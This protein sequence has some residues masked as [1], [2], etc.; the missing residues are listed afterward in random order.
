MGNEASRDH[1]PHH[2]TFVDHEGHTYEIAA[3]QTPHQTTT[4]SKIEDVATTDTPESPT[5]IP[6]HHIPPPENNYDDVVDPILAAAAAGA[7]TKQTS[8]ER[9]RHQIA[10]S[11]RAPF[12]IQIDSDWQTSLQRLAK[13][14]KST[15]QTIA[16][17]AAPIMQEAAIVMKE[18]TA[19][20]NKSNREQS[21]C[22][23][24]INQGYQSTL[25]RQ[26]DL[27]ASRE[28]QVTE[29]NPRFKSSTRSPNT[30]VPNEEL[31]EKCDKNELQTFPPEQNPVDEEQQHDNDVT[32]HDS[33]TPLRRHRLIPLTSTPAAVFSGDFGSA[34]ADTKQ[35]S[36]P[37]SPYLLISPISRSTVSSENQATRPFG[38]KCTST[39]YTISVNDHSKSLDSEQQREL[40]PTPKLFVELVTQKLST[41]EERGTISS[42]WR[43][44]QQSRISSR[45]ASRSGSITPQM[46]DWTK[47]TLAEF[48]DNAF[49]DERNGRSRSPSMSPPGSPMEDMVSSF[50]NS[51]ATTFAGP[52]I[53]LWD[54]IPTK[55]PNQNKQD[56]ISTSVSIESTSSKVSKRKVLMDAKTS[57]ELRLTSLDQESGTASSNSDLTSFPRS[58]DGA[59]K[60]RKPTISFHHVD[61]GSFCSDPGKTPVKKRK[62]SCHKDF[63]RAKSNKGSFLASNDSY[64]IK[65][66]LT[67]DTDRIRNGADGEINLLPTTVVHS[68]HQP[69]VDVE[70]EKPPIPVHDDEI[71]NEELLA[72][73]SLSSIGDGFPS[74]ELPI[75]LSIIAELRWRQLLAQWKHGA[76]INAIRKHPCYLHFS[77]H[78]QFPDDSS[79]CSDTFTTFSSNSTAGHYK[80]RHNSIFNGT[81]GSLQ[82]TRN[83][84]GF[85]PL[86]N[87]DVPTLTSYLTTL[88]RHSN[89]HSTTCNDGAILKHDIFGEMSI[90]D[91]VAFATTKR[92]SFSR[93]T[94]Q[95]A[96][97]AHQN[98]Q[99]VKDINQHD[100]NVS[101]SVDIKGTENIRVKACRK[102]GGDVTQVKDILRSQLVFPDE[103]SLVC[104]MIFLNR[105]ACV[106]DNKIS[107]QA[108]KPEEM[109][110]FE[111]EIIRVKNL[112]SQN[113]SQEVEKSPLPTGYR[114]ILVT[115]R[116]LDGFLAGKS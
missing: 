73:S 70:W 88:T 110:D 66:S 9:K 109:H 29:V 112:F 14:A 80:R 60:R 95:I 50:K 42:H 103:G 97:I 13:T 72:F 25:D 57:L 89:V 91:L 101:F 2:E 62:N 65:A 116:T 85:N 37:T 106:S 30:I 55:N 61:T 46:Q 105:L 111:F 27:D 99:S 104:A 8:I 86:G 32:K 108:I 43:S 92:H 58:T 100:F 93:L 12:R 87:D 11:R 53:D 52:I 64:P 17:A 28:L 40:L 78:L 69:E 31:L 75:N 79:H 10:H 22:V 18:S 102:Y 41:T 96:T 77:E 1:H 98:Y 44:Q 5:K 68:Y 90:D 48:E 82:S 83:L 6:L 54:M 23:K 113:H 81:M 107:P 15:A 35:L 3:D 114:H 26:N 47:S 33:F 7:A 36:Q 76:I 67:G 19:V 94:E 4:K 24:Q 115:V 16:S 59:F 84:S 63:W 51:T 20:L 71:I 39:T 74:L 49:A 45:L 38:T 21:D 34:Y 56:H